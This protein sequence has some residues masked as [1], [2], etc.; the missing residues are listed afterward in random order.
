MQ[1]TLSEFVAIV[2]KPNVGKSSLL[3][4]MIEEKLAI[5]S[6][7]PQTTRNRI[8][9]VYTKD[10]L[11]IV[12][13]DTPGLHKPKTK[14]G[15]YMVKQVESSVAE[16]D[17]AVL[18]VDVTAKEVSEA[19]K[20]LISSF[21]SMHLPAVLAINKIDTVQDKAK[22]LEK[23]MQ[24]KNLYDFAAIVPVSAVRKEG[25]KELREEI[26]RF[27][28][29]GPHFFDGDSYTDQPERVIAAEII[30][31]KLLRNLY[32]E[33]PHGT[34]VIIESMKERPNAGLLDIHATIYCEKASHKGMIIGRGG[35]M[36]KK[37]ASQSR[38][39]LENFLG[40]RVNLQCWVKVREDWRSNENS[41]R[42]F[43]YI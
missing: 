19:D 30:R 41:I 23:I 12:F 38:A 9:G 3:N 36:L 21:Q 7:K 35:Q 24:Y 11:Q 27:A 15:E 14:L 10:E 37:I 34:A 26:R 13:I 18:V 1:K 22:I 42:S 6:E 16:V 17:A 5:I 29:E 25:V 31:E 43:G 40:I 2:G 33:I 20:E 32:D 4:A 8:T 39:E 28:K